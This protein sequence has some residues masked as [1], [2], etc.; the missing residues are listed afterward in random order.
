MS[1]DRKTLDRLRKSLGPRKFQLIAW[2][3]SVSAFVVIWQEFAWLLRYTDVEWRLYVPYPADVF[4]VLIESFV[5][6]VPGIGRSM[7]TMALASLERVIMG[8]VLAL[9]V[10][11]PLGLLMASFTFVR[12]LGDPIVEMF[13]P[14][15]PVAWIPVFIVMFSMFWGPVAVVFLGAFF[16]ILLNVMFGVKRTDQ[17]LIDAAKTLGASRI[18]IFVKVVIPSTAPYLM[19]GVKIGLGIGWMCIV[20]AEM[21]PVVGGGVG[22]A[23]WTSA[24]Q[25]SRYDVTFACMIV[26]GLLSIITTGFAEQVERRLYRWMGME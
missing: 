21:L 25:F 12:H 17:T 22:Y 16:P 23:L 10:A 19:T 20:A 8:F 2:F 3:V 1:V 14:V 26:I 18:D 7:G 11:F 6:E 9:L 24:L 4:D 5:D 13:R 15:P